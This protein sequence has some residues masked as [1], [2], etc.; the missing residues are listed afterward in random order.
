MLELE[1]GQLHNASHTRQVPALHHW[2][3]HFYKTELQALLLTQQ[4]LGQSRLPGPRNL[5][6]LIANTTLPLSHLLALNTSSERW[7]C[8]NGTDLQLLMKGSDVGRVYSGS[9]SSA[10]MRMQRIPALVLEPAGETSV[11]H[12]LAGFAASPR[13]GLSEDL[14]RKLFKHQLSR[15]R[16]PA[17]PLGEATKSGLDILLGLAHGMR[18]LHELGIVH[19]DLTE[20]G[21]NA[22]ITRD[23]L[24]VTSVLI[25][26]SQ[27]DICGAGSGSGAKQVDLYS[28]GNVLHFACYGRVMHSVSWK[29]Y[30]CSS[31]ARALAKLHQEHATTH[32]AVRADVKGLLNRCNEKLQPLLEDLMRLCWNPITQP[33]ANH[34]FE[35]SEIIDRL[36]AAKE[37]NKPLFRF[38]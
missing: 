29:Q 9:G 21:K 32:L 33:K 17:S 26:L 13:E 15:A 34:D 2:G 24:G 25:D 22:L 30:S 37:M 8:L 10:V 28:F 27:A 7:S 36:Q 38:M 11:F 4:K 12:W 19:R 35:W 1:N 6:R 20:P 3:F 5:V 18:Q 31:S 14:Q 16:K 23:A